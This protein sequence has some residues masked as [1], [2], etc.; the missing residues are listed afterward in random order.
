M[1]FRLRLQHLLC[2][3]GRWR[4]FLCECRTRC[5]QR[6]PDR[7]CAARWLKEG[8]GYDF[9][10][11]WSHSIDNSSGSEASIGTI[12]NS[13][14]PNSN[15]G[16]SDFD[17][18]HNVTANFVVELPFGDGKK[19]LAH[20]HESGGRCGILKRL[21]SIFA[22]YCT[23]RYCRSPR[24]SN[25]GI[26]SVNYLSS[27]LGYLKP[28]ATMPATA[29]FDQN[30]IPSLFANTNAVNS[31]VGEYPG[32]SGPRGILRGP[33][34][35][36]TDLSV[37]KY[38]KLPWEGHRLGIR[39]EAFNA[40]NNVNFLTVAPNGATTGNVSATALRRPLPSENSVP[41]PTPA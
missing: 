17:I 6:A 1:H 19:F 24:V 4:N 25:G 37:S 8:W 18:R 15:K 14:D 3:S 40:F 30:G 7:A 35:Y 13:F 39:A 2:S 27:A 5:L 28:G 31:F 38:F 11:T 33:A 29:S 41:L 34:F 26:Y 36:N 21:A 12:Q 22:R 20:V 23:L 9:N 32:T 10:Y 16:P